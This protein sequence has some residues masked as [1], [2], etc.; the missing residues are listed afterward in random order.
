MKKAECVISRLSEAVRVFGDSTSFGVTRAK[1]CKTRRLMHAAQIKS[2]DIDH[3][4][5]D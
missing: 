1:D 5:S 2:F 3:E 4:C